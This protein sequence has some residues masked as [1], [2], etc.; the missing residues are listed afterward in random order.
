MSAENPI[1]RFQDLPRL[2]QLFMQHVAA[3]QVDVSTATQFAVA[4]SSFMQARQ[5]QALSE[6][7]YFISASTSLHALFHV[8][9][10]FAAAR[11]QLIGGPSIPTQETV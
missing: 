2:Y 6:G 3:D 5:Q 10:M 11:K 8:P 1:E 7:R 9:E 4:L